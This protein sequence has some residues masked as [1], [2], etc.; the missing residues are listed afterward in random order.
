MDLSNI[1]DNNFKEFFKDIFDNFRKYQ[2][3]TDLNLE[4]MRH[5]AEIF[6]NPIKFKFITYKYS[7]NTE[8]KY[9]YKRYP[10][11]LKNGIDFEENV[12]QEM[13]KYN[14]INLKKNYLNDNKDKQLGLEQISI[15][16]LL[17]SIF[18]EKTENY[19]I[20]QIYKIINQIENI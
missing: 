2:R 18:R 5:G 9:Y 20:N 15:F 8:I 10:S 13:T 19:N 17:E 11:D 12:F 3:D 6:F 14:I 1:L 16:E 7:E 4:L